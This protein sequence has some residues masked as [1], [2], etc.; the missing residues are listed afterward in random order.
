METK[1]QNINE[2]IMEQ[3]VRNENNVNRQ[4]LND[5]EKRREK[6]GVKL[7]II[8]LLCLL[9]LIPWMIIRSTISDR[10]RTE[11][12]AEKEVF[13]KWGGK[14]TL[15][16]PAIRVIGNEKEND[17]LLLPETLDIVSDART[18]TL[19]RG[20]YDF[21]VY[22]A[23][24][25][26]KGRFIMPKNM[27][28]AQLGRLSQNFW[29][30]EVE[31][32]S[33]KGLTDNPT[34]KLNGR[35]LSLQDVSFEDSRLM[36]NADLSR[37]IN[38]DSMDF[39]I[40]IQLRGS[41]SLKY[42]PTGNTTTVKMTSDCA[43]PS[44]CGNFL[45]TERNVRDDGFDAEWK[46][47]AINRTFSQIVDGTK[48]RNMNQDNYD[49]LIEDNSGDDSFGVELK[50]PVEQY[51]QNERA[52]KYAYLIVLLTFAIVFFIEF[53]RDKP[54]HLVQY[55]LVGIAIMLFYTLL[56]SFSEHLSFLVAYIIATVMTVMLLAF[57]LGGIMHDRK[58]GMLLGGVL[59]V[60]Y[61][62]IYILLQIE[63]YALLVGSI[64]LFVVLAIAMAASRK[65]EWY[66]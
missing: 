2:N 27:T 9:L 12:G 36:W 19:N 64:G 49:Y 44:F 21:T 4:L 14:Q 34:I 18:R 7:L 59:A 43:T 25:V 29:K 50:R 60:C 45:P 40:T 13:A 38:G 47:L 54:I 42:I 26:M 28:D 55:L 62:F 37:L 65:V 61:T 20:I 3:Q 63:S 48:W 46:V 11:S 22:D 1:N 53:R 51:Q 39:E 17:F 6:I 30:M 31:L 8:T 58:V 23:T 33:L 57:Y 5:G 32:S 41:N 15:K 16:G 35:Q 10:D 24:V 66:K 52:V 56:L